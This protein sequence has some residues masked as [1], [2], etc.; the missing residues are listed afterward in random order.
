[1]IKLL[2]IKDIKLLL[3]DHK[4]QVFFI[5]LII[6]FIFSA[7]SNSVTYKSLSNEYQILLNAHLD[8]VQSENGITLWGLI[9]AP[10]PVSVINI[11]TPSVLFSTYENF[12]EVMRSNIFSYIPFPQRLGITGTENFQLN[13][14]FILGVLMGFIMLI[15][16]FEAFSSEK[17]SGTLRLLSVYGFKRQAILWSKYLTYMILYL[18]II[19]P[20][21]LISMILFFSLTGTW[22]MIYFF[23][24][25]TIILLSIPFASF[26]ALLGIFISMAK[27]FRIAIVIVVFV[28][29]LFLIMIPQSANIFGKLLSPLKTN[30]EYRQLVVTAYSN[31]WALKGEEYGS[32]F[33]TY[34]SR[35]FSAK[36]QNSANEKSDVFIQR[37]LED[38]RRQIRSI[39]RIASLSPFDQFE[40]ISEI[41]FDK[42]SYLMFFQEQ[43]L[44]TVLTQV[45]N[46]MIEQDKNDQDSQN[47][48]YQSAPE[49]SRRWEETLFSNQKFD[50]P[51]LL[52]VTNIPT[53]DALTKTV[54]ITLRL[55][56]IILLNL[57]LIVCSVLKLERL[58]I[59]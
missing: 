49:D 56:V 9:D 13:W 12:P 39:Q 17:R 24:F 45:R 19:I 59:R 50:H 36:A 18:V 37:R 6:L 55:S 34:N 31:E 33:G 46:I 29:L 21:S 26:F 10:N 42:G 58:D 8:K 27:N 38:E 53:D 11:P 32:G 22:D 52:F 16:S 28:W 15:L 1:M 47:L 44:R 51:N 7:I 43:T 35:E 54:K 25:L 57:L 30:A 20:P 5:V 4:Y 41:I 3:K 2:L 40:K 48:F 23:K 14:F